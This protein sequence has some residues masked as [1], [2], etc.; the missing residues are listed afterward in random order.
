MRAVYIIGKQYSGRAGADQIMP[1]LGLDLKNMTTEDDRLYM[2]VAESC[3]EWGYI[4]SIADRYRAVKITEKG[5]EY[6]KRVME[7]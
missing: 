3:Q 7:L 5:K 4:E 6:V 1:R 2:N